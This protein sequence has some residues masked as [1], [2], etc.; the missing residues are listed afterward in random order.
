MLQ[1]NTSLDFLLEG[2]MARYR[3][4]GFLAGDQIRFKESILNNATFKALSDESRAV[5]QTLI[6]KE[7][8]GDAIIKVVSINA[9]LMMQDTP[10]SEPVSM[11]V[12]IDGGG[13][14][15]FDVVCLPGQ[16]IADIERIIPTPNNLQ[17]AIAPG[18]CI[19]YDQL[20]YPQEVTPEDEEGTD[21]TVPHKQKPQMLP[22]E[23][24]PDKKAKKPQEPDSKKA[25]KSTLSDGAKIDTSAKA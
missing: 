24:Q 4:G 13:G 21:V 23:Q 22:K 18:R 11:D 9:P 25:I 5:L 16:L 6:D 8:A 10:Y 15:M 17:Q 7:K 2:I 12:G 20:S 1:K 19:D 3:I 14:A